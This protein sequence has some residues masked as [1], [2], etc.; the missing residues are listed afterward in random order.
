M[1]KNF[2]LEY[3]SALGL[4]ISTDGASGC[5]YDIKSTTPEGIAQEIGKCAEDYV[6]TFLKMGLGKE[7]NNG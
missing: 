2:L 7:E 6:Y 4:Y 3:D 1:K 5:S